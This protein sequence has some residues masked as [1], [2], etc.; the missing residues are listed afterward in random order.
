MLQLKNKTLSTA[1]AQYTIE[2]LALNARSYL[3]RAR[4]DAFINFKSRL[5][6]YVQMKE[7]GAPNTELNELVESLKSEH[8]QTV[9]HEMI[10]Q[11]GLHP[12]INDLFNRAPEALTWM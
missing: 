1:I 8:H 11:R 10:R 2:T 4:R 9:W 12:Q 3:V 6:T 7:A 5:F